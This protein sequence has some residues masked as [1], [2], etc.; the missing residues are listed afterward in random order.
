MDVV[1]PSLKIQGVFW[2]SHGQRLFFNRISR[3]CQWYRVRAFV[4]T[5]PHDCPLV[6]YGQLQPLKRKACSLLSTNINGFFG[7]FEPNLKVTSNIVLYGLLRYLASWDSLQ[8]P[9]Q[10]VWSWGVFTAGQN[11]LSHNIHPLVYF[12]LPLSKL[13]ADLGT[14]TFYGTGLR[15]AIVTDIFRL[16]A[17]AAAGP[18]R[19]S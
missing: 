2:F 9:K 19:Q 17:A 4:S 15:C 11:P 3:Q 13:I 10:S 18:L 6:Q 16:K 1:R 14:I 12:G 8:W 5:A 7:S